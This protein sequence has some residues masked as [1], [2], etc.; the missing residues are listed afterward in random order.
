MRKLKQ[1]WCAPKVRYAS[2]DEAALVLVDCKIRASL[3]HRAHRREDH[4]YY[5]GECNGFHLSSIP[6][7]ERN[8]HEDVRPADDGV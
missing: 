1:R 6:A 4:V 5:C 7:R 8:D 2:Y 3:K